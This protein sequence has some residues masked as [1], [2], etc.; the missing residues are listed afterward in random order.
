MDRKYFSCRVGHEDYTNRW[1][2][3]DDVCKKNNIFMLH[4]NTQNKGCIQSIEEGDILFLLLGDNF[5]TFAQA[6][7]K[8][9]KGI[10]KMGYLEEIKEE[11]FPSNQ[12]N[13]EENIHFCHVSKWIYGNPVD[14]YGIKV[15]TSD[16]KILDIVKEIKRKFACEII[17]KMI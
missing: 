4:D 2:V 17:E 7:T 13:C 11:D 8:I 1:H 12:N 15:N 6:M 9:K 5:V 3:I 14:R 16:G 10:L